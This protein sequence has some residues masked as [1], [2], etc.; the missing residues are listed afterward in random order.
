M[1]M[2]IHN[3]YKLEVRYRDDGHIVAKTIEED[4][5]MPSILRVCRGDLA[6]CHPTAIFLH[7]SHSFSPTINMAKT[8]AH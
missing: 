1:S 7:L 4:C 3:M 5:H 8:Q 6:Q 2:Y